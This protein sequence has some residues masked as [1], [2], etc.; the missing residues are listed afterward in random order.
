MSLRRGTLGVRQ[1]GGTLSSKLQDLYV[2]L[3]KTTLQYYKQKEQYQKR[4]APSERIELADV[5]E[6]HAVKSKTTGYMF[7]VKSQRIRS[8]H[9]CVSDEDRQKW[10]YIIMKAKTD[11][12]STSEDDDG[13]DL[14]QDSSTTNSKSDANLDEVMKEVEVERLTER[15]A[16]LMSLSKQ[17]RKE[18]LET[19]LKKKA[20]KD[21]RKLLKKW[22]DDKSEVLDAL[23]RK[24]IEAIE[25]EYQQKQ[26]ELLNAMQ[27]RKAEN[28]F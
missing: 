11:G 3:S 9:I 7:E 6:V 23:R 15:R 1:R 10:V 20:R 22:K 8:Q 13:A 17:E 19:G 14:S 5:T 28:V 25:T 2:V 18:L 27:E 16:Y 4:Q 26:L 12:L 21:R 24:E